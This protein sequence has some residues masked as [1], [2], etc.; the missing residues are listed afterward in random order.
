MYNSNKERKTVL[1][2]F[3]VFIFILLS[4]YMSSTSLAFSQNQTPDILGVNIYN[5]EVSDTYNPYPRRVRVVVGDVETYHLV[6]SLKTK[7]ILNEIGYDIDF[8]DE[9][10][11]PADEFVL[12]N[13]KIILNL[14]ESELVEELESI[15]FKTK[16]IA[17][18]NVK[19]GNERIEIQGEEGLRRKIIRKTYKNGM[20]VKSEEVERETILEPITQVVYYGS[21]PVAV[22]NCT[23]WNRVID[24]LVSRT[25]YPEKNAWMRY[26]MLCE[27]GCNSDKNRERYFVGSKNF[28]GLYQFTA[29]TFKAYGGK[30]LFDG[31]Q[32][33]EVVSRMY[34]LTGNPAHHWPACNRAFERDYN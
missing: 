15:P 3:L 32:Q 11:P 5:E 8:N 29:Q 17:E 34:D 14:I 22:H 31:Y 27:S 18:P 4:L 33:I 16:R 20:L 2:E 9:M 6:Y 21:K 12:D 10:F 13:G 28:Y 19:R 1:A 30:D 25:K 7:D 23:Y 26:V 24:D